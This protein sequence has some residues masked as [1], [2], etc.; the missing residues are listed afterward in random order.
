MLRRLVRIFIILVLLLALVMGGATGYIV[1]TTRRVL[2][3]ISGTL[4]LPGLK[5]EV[6]VYRD[7]AGIPQIYA[8]T[9]NTLAKI[10]YGLKR[11]IL[12]KKLIL[13]DLH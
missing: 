13:N 1:Y 3:Q 10:H 8:S 2:P 12:V 5:G 6:R 11:L 4:S 9:S 7:A